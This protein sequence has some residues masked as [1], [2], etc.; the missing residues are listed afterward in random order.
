[1]RNLCLVSIFLWFG[2]TAR[3]LELSPFACDYYSEDGKSW[4]PHSSGSFHYTVELGWNSTTLAYISLLRD[5]KNGVLG[6]CGYIASAMPNELSIKTY[7]VSGKNLEMVPNGDACMFSGTELKYEPKVE[8]F[9][10]QNF[11]TSSQSQHTFGEETTYFLD[12]VGVYNH[13]PGEDP[14]ALCHDFVRSR[15]LGIVVEAP[16]RK[17]RLWN[18]ERKAPG[19]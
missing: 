8:W 3:A 5:G 13:Q 15:G 7:V 12:V 4:I 6:S 11:M 17:Q 19:L 18:R 16:A 10:D 14:S 2:T 9:R 1:M